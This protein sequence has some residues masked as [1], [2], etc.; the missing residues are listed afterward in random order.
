[1]LYPDP[2][3][4]SISEKKRNHLEDCLSNPS[5]IDMYFSVHCELIHRRKYEYAGQQKITSGLFFSLINVKP[6]IMQKPLIPVL[7]RQRH[8]GI[9]DFQA[10]QR[11]IMG[12]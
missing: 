10:R 11:C 2:D 8:G 6:S 9:S 4:V 1:M 5:V 7:G 12:P 3:A